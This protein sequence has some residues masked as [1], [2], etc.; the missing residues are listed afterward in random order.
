MLND[1]EH[2]HNVFVLVV[3]DD[4]NHSDSL[5]S[6]LL[7]DPLGEIPSE[8][9]ATP[10]VTPTTSVVPILSCEDMECGVALEIILASAAAA[11]VLL[12]LLA[13]SVIVVTV[14]LCTSS[15]KHAWKRKS[16]AGE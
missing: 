9:V 12:L 3:V 4:N 15:S 2:S 1:V 6:D 8:C 14:L 13:V 10:T 7:C 5:E 16:Q 11:L